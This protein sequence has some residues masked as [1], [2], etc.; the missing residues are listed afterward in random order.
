MR[1]IDAKFKKP[2]NNCNLRKIIYH[3]YLPMFM[4]IFN[5]RGAQTDRF[6][7]EVFQN[8]F[9]SSMNT[10]FLR[11][12][13]ATVPTVYGIETTKALFFLFCSYKLQ[14][15]LPFTVLKQGKWGTRFGKFS[16]QQ[17]LPFT[18]LKLGTATFSPI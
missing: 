16:L 1:N 15:Y 12:T 17:Y 4:S 6:R 10:G 8:L 14:Q 7:Y 5:L 11:D 3:Q 13:V 9:F 2:Y 18:V